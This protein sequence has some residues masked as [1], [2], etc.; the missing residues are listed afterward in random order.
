MEQALKV[1]KFGG[2]S[3][4]DADRIQQVAAIITQDPSIK[5]VVVSAPEGMTDQL[6]EIGKGP[7]GGSFGVLVGDVSRRFTNISKDLSDNDYNA[8]LQLNFD[9]QKLHESGLACDEPTTVS[10]GEYICA[11]LV[12]AHLGF[13]FLDAARFM[14]FNADGEFDFEATKYA[15]G[16]LKLELGKRYV[17]PGFYGAMPDGAIK[18]FSR[19]ASDY[20]AAVV[21]AC[22][23]ATLLEKWTNE[24]GIR[25]ADPRIVPDAE[26]IDELTF[27]EIRELTSRGTKILHPEVI[28]PLREAMIPIEIKNVDRPH[29]RGTRI[30]PNEMAAPKPPGT[31]VGI[32][33]A[34]GYAVFGIEKM[35]MRMGFAAKLLGV[36]AE[37][38]VD[39]AHIVDGVD[40]MGIVVDEKEIAG[41]KC[42][43]LYARIKAVCKPDMLNVDHAMTIIGVVGHWM[44]N[45]PGTLAKIVGAVADIGVSIEIADQSKNQTNIV[46][47]VADRDCDATVRA[48]Y[49]RMI[50]NK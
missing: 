20:S 29:E 38:K 17:I 4:R 10:R 42:G 16:A 32:S 50:R 43:E 18:L 28:V 5:F 27:R 46:L 41:E 23:K 11:K 24:S 12:A 1:A 33:S 2:S 3:L 31:V 21:A 36:F 40:E 26:Y 35:P 15:W 13:E 6:I 47:G 7:K 34:K 9:L 37:L 19:N 48:V 14:Y 39:I 8:E 49:D 25:R 22:A 44:D 30:V 45:A